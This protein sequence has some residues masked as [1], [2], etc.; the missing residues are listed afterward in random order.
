[1]GSGPPEAS[2]V[3]DPIVLV[4][5]S[6]RDRAPIG[7]AG[8]LAGNTLENDLRSMVPG[9][10]VGEAD[11][12][13]V[14]QF[15]RFC[16]GLGTRCVWLR[17]MR[18]AS[19]TVRYDATGADLTVCGLDGLEGRDLGP[20]V[21]K[22][23]WYRGLPEVPAF[24]TEEEQAFAERETEAFWEGYGH[25]ARV[26]VLSRPRTAGLRP[27]TWETMLIRHL[28]GTGTGLPIPADGLATPHLFQPSGWV[29][30]LY[31]TLSTRRVFRPE[32]S[33]GCDEQC[34]WTDSPPLGWWAVL[35]VH[36]GAGVVL[37]RPSGAGDA[38]VLAPAALPPGLTGGLTEAARCMGRRLGED[39]GAAL[40]DVDPR[41]GQFAF[42]D[43]TP[44]PDGRV[45]TSLGSHLFPLIWRFLTSPRTGAEP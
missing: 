16:A 13:L 32:E 24:P 12:E 5:G 27:A 10:D 3:S 28:V 19:L 11:H 4:I 37:A 2:I 14:E 18:D 35:A 33:A 8:L 9:R 41:E 40:F 42:R 22:G 45:V 29:P 31:Q 43:Y 6:R 20:S 1:M 39:F 44:T 30:R 36:V 26:P 23:V 17:R 21:V 38:E 7:L 25:H 34:V 15:G